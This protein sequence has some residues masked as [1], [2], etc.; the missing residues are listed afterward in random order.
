MKL[1]VWILLGLAAMAILVSGT[2]VFKDASHTKS[3]TEVFN[4]ILSESY[5]GW[6][7]FHTCLTEPAPQHD[8]CWA[9]LHRGNRY[10]LIEIDLDLSNAN[11]VPTEVA[12]HDPWTRKPMHLASPVG[13]GS[14][15]TMVYGWEY[16]MS[17]IDA[18]KLPRSFWD[19]E[20]DPSAF[21][22]QMFLFT[23]GGTPA[24]VKC[25]NALGDRI[26]Y[27]PTKR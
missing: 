1:R 15:N 3:G 18:H 19:V 9:E 14:V 12:H 17:T 11:A 20:G 27:T 16:L 25:G 2:P 4:T 23:C 13:H 7:G 22:P 26:S 6:T 5:A 21:P 10:R 8:L 24:L